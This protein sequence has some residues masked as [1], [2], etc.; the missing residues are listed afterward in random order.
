LA[1]TVFF[2]M[3]REGGTLYIFQNGG[4][5]LR[6]ARTIEW[7]D[8]GGL[9]V[10][11]LPD[12]IRDAYLSL[13]LSELDFRILELP[14]DDT[15]RI[16]EVLPFELEGLVLGG[17]S[18]AVL[19][20]MVLGKSGGQNLVLAVY[21]KKSTLRRYLDALGTLGVDPRTV[22]SIELAQT[23]EASGGDREALG[24]ALLSTPDIPH[25]QRAP[26][27]LETMKQPQ[28]NFRRD[29]FA[30]TQDVKKMQ[31]TM[32]FI[33]GALA[34]LILL[35]AGDIAIRTSSAQREAAVLEGRIAEAYTQMFPGEK[36]SSTTGLAYRLQ[37][38]MKEVQEKSGNLT[39]VE[40][41]EF[42]LSLKQA[43]PGGVIFKEITLD[44][45]YVSLKGEAPSLSAVEDVKR[46][47]EGFLSDVKITDS[48]QAASG[49]YAFSI[50]AKGGTK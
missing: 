20:A 23:V 37:A 26:R 22:T 19:D 27:A 17:T 10:G 18:G 5:T 25:A 3:T 44:R 36:L 15:D 9:R 42:L 24:H 39:G 4:G 46:K 35:L 45:E 32:G 13:P 2:D 50:A 8:D 38:R 7:A 31:R 47:L 11:G 34:I 43:T 49:Q 16:R 1:S 29:E 14:L 21:V 33:I 30:F 48:G 6:D 12:D 40:P 41:L 28:V